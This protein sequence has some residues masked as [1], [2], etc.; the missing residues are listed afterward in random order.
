[1]REYLAICIDDDEQFL[2]SLES[3]LPDKVRPLCEQ[4]QCKFEFVSTP[5]ELQ[6]ILAAGAADG[7]APAMV[8]ADQVMPGITGIELIEKLRRSHPELVCVLL[9][10]HAGLDNAKYAINHGLLDQYVSKPVED[11]HAF[12]SLVANLLR[13]HHLELEER[14]RTQ[15]LARTVE[16]LRVSNEKITAMHAAAEQVAMLSKGLKCLEFDEVVNIVT[17]EVPRIFGA[18]W[19]ILCFPEG[20]CPA[21]G[22]MLLQRKD[23]PCPQDKLAGRA[24]AAAACGTATVVSG[25]VPPPCGAAGAKSPNVVIPLSISQLGHDGGQGERTGYLCLCQLDSMAAAPEIISYKGG[26]VREVL[27]ANLTNARL[28][29]EARRRSEVDALTETATRRVLEEKL[30]AEFD[31]AV[32]YQHAFCVAMLDVDF[33]K[34]VNDKSGHAAGDQALRELGRV[35]RSAA[36]STDLLARYGGDEFVL[37]M[38]ETTLPQAAQSVERL[39]SAVEADAGTA[40]LTISCGVAEWSRLPNDTGANVVR[41]ADAALYQAKHAGRNRTHLSA[42]PH[43]AAG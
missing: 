43:T 17:Q 18:R 39:R 10:G 36:R 12:A 42:P 29:Q 8:I 11:M 37:L 33:F 7:R 40:G 30:E 6:D 14:L 3:S 19:G 9:T 15:Q 16:E 41:R 2:A 38:P 21:A 26:L 23:C 22:D 13:A 31:R 20:P 27:S 5:Q 1:M 35:L 32:R 24:D 28:Y 4:F 34:G 25:L